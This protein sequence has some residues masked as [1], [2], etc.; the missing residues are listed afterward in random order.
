MA[1]LLY[2][3][4][5]TREMYVTGHDLVWHAVFALQIP[6]LPDISTTGHVLLHI[7]M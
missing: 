4:S 7:S 5:L 3:S 1:S 2:V 6:A